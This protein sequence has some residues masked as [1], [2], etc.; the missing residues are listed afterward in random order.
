MQA[1]YAHIMYATKCNKS[2]NF[3]IVCVLFFFLWF[4]LQKP[5]KREFKVQGRMVRSKTM[6]HRKK[7]ECQK[8]AKEIQNENQNKVITKKAK[9]TRLN[10]Q[11]I[12]VFA[13]AQNATQSSRFV[14]R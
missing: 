14:T 1:S 8:L 5:E 13:H 11:H 12:P 2:L 10:I 4:S 7:D 6:E 3:T 9:P